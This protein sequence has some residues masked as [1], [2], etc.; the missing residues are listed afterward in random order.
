MYKYGIGYGARSGF[1]WN[2]IQT[3]LLGAVFLFLFLFRFFTKLGIVLKHSNNINL[4][5]YALSMMGF[6][7]IILLD[8]II[9]SSVF[10]NIG[11]ISNT[12]YFY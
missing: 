4:K 5:F 9:Y 12:F 7:F 2:M 8:Y 3:G 6:L 10:F 1:L 11:A